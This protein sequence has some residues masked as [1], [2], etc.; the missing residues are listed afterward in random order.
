MTRSAQGGAP[1][2]AHFQQ[3]RLRRAQA[4]RTLP[5]KACKD[6]LIEDDRGET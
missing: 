2:Q 4:D 5:D 1:F 3:D 6:A